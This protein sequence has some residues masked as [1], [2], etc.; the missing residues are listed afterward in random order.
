MLPEIV[1]FGFHLPTYFI[2]LSLVFSGL[3]LWWHHKLQVLGRDLDL[4]LNLALFIMVCGF[5]GA[6]FLHVILE[7]PSHYRQNFFDIFRFWQGGFVYYGGLIFGFCGAFFYLKLWNYKHKHFNVPMQ[8]WRVWADDLAPLLS[9]GYVL[10]RGACFL[11]GCCYGKF[12]DLPWAVGGRHPTQIYASV[13]EVVWLAWILF[14]GRGFWKKH[15]GR[16]FFLWL[17]G[18]SALRIPMEFLRDDPRGF[19]W[20]TWSPS[21]LLSFGLIGISLIYLVR[22]MRPAPAD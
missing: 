17:F 13:A 12:C 21:S 1:L 14:A 7:E 9:V 4:G 3:L 6:R 16:L 5:L 11:N 8:D 2:A 10:G 18:H 22:T 19:F 20:G 15:P